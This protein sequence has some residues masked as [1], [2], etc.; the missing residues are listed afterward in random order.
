MWITSARWVDLIQS[1]ENHN[2]KKTKTLVLRGKPVAACLNTQ[3]AAL[4]TCGSKNSPLQ[5]SAIT[6]TGFFRCRLLGQTL[7]DTDG[8][9]KWLCFLKNW[10]IQGLT[11][12]RPLW[13]SYLACFLYYNAN[14]T[15][16]YFLEITVLSG[17]FGSVGSDQIFVSKRTT[18]FLFFYFWSRQDNRST[19][20]LRIFF[21]FKTQ[22]C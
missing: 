2:R 22:R 10:L 12:P 7:G 1:L 5:V 17:K 21:F 18:V 9:C 15:K 13:L 4:S 16:I 20:S 8:P 3:A 6:W 11:F 19:F 14:F